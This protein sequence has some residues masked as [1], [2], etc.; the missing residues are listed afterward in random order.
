[1]SLTILGAHGNDVW[2]ETDGEL[3]S[4]SAADLARL[5]RDLTT[6]FFMGTAWHYHHEFDESD[7]TALI[8]ALNGPQL[9]DCHDCE[10]PGLIDIE[11]RMVC[12]GCANGYGIA[13]DESVAP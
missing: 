4:L 1:M 5:R 12:P 8:H 7:V 10:Q 6:P 3:Y 13:E 9:D 11:G 2:V